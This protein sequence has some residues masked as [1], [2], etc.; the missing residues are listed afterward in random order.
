MTKS[1]LIAYLETLHHQILDLAAKV[2][3]FQVVVYQQTL[4]NDD[5]DVLD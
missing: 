5:A 3:E 4:D 2:K 1:E